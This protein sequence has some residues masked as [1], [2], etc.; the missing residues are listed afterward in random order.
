MPCTIPTLTT[1]HNGITISYH[2]KENIWCFELRGKERFRNTLLEAKA[3]IDAPA[4][5]DKVPF[6]RT[7]AFYK[8]FGAGIDRVEVTSVAALPG[9]ASCRTEYWIVDANKNRLKVWGTD[10][11]AITPKNEDLVSQIELNRK[12]IE[13]LHGV[14]I[15]LA[16]NLDKFTPP[17]DTE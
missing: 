6:K 17:K 11:F 14:N 4:P 3:A 7:P 5:K 12:E 2:E 10:L 15:E 16:E 13:H 9:Y 1:T 8:H